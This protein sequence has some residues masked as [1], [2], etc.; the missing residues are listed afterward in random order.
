MLILDAVG[1]QIRLSG[2]QLIREISLLGCRLLGLLGRI[3]N[4][5]VLSI[6]I[7]NA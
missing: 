5:A 4:P 3:C 6:S 1:F 7:C 2:Y